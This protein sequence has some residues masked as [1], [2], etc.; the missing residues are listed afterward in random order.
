MIHLLLGLG[1]EVVT[2]REPHVQVVPEAPHV[3]VRV[4]EPHDLGGVHHVALVVRR[5]LVASVD[6]RAHRVLELPSIRQRPREAAAA[7]VVRIEDGDRVAGLHG[8]EG[9][10][11]QAPP[12]ELDDPLRRVVALGT[13]RAAHGG[14]TLQ[15]LV[16]VVIDKDGRIFFDGAEVTE[17]DLLKAAEL[18]LSDGAIVNNAR[19]VLDAEE[20]LAVYR[21]AF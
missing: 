1:V 17:E 21:T 20:V 3:R 8:V 13:I 5:Q 18:S 4:L 16:N 6:V 7:R 9:A 19:M 14:E 15:G 12:V 2:A 11:Q 10:V